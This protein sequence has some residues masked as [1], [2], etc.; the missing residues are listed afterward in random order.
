MKKISK[1]FLEGFKINDILSRLKISI[2]IED[3]FN[4]IS[5]FKICYILFILKCFLL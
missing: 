5:K 3:F 2:D 1:K 4:M